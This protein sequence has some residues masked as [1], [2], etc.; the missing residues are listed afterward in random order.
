MMLHLGIVYSVKRKT[1]CSFKIFSKFNGFA[2][3][4]ILKDLD[5]KSTIKAKAFKDNSIHLFLNLRIENIK[6]LK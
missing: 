4:K 2:G 1:S 6:K 5:P 3:N